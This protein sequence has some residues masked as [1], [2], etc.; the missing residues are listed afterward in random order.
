MSN[1]NRQRHTVAHAVTPS[2]Q[3]GA[4]AC[5]W[6]LS[7]FSVLTLETVW[8]REIAL[9]VGSTAVAS[10]LVIAVFFASAAL[11]NL[12]GAA[13]VEGR[14]RAL[15]FY[16]YFETSAAVSAA[17]LFVV[18]RWL[19]AHGA[20]FPEGWYGAVGA[21]ALLV[22]LPSFLSG[23]AFPSLAE[24]FVADATHR[25]STG[26]LFYG[27]NLFGAGLGVAAGGV[28]LPWHVGSQGAFFVAAGMQFA[29]GLL[30]W[31]IAVSYVPRER[32]AWPLHSVMVLPGWTGWFLLAVSGFLSLAAQTLL[33]VWARQVVEGSV[34]V[35]CGVLAVFLSGLGI[36]GLVVSA[37]RRKGFRAEDLLT[38]F[39]GTSGMLLSAV[40]TVGTVLCARDVLLKANTPSGL[41]AE[42][43]CGSAVLLLPLTFCLGGVFPVAWELVHASRK[44][45]GAVL[46]AAMALNKVGAAAGT[47]LGLFAVMPLLGLARGT[48]LIAWGYLAIACLPA[49]LLRRFAGWRAVYLVLIA[50]LGL[51]QMVRTPTVLGVHADECVVASSEGAYGPVVVVENR[52]SASR[53]ILLNSRQRLSGTQRALSSQHHQS[54]VSLLFCR[55]PSRVLTIGMAAGISATAALDFPLRELHSVE[56][57]PE[58]VDLA[59]AHFGEWN[60]AL[61]SDPRSQVHT[62]DGRAKLDRLSDGFDAIICDLFFPGE[63]GTANLYSYEF[64]RKCRQ[65]LNPGGV[66]CL[67]LPCYQHT[68]ETAGVI[69][70]TFTEVF[71]NAVALRANL[72]PLQPVLGLLGADEPIPVSK[73]FLAKQLI[74][75]VGRKLASQSVFFRSAEAAMLLFVA[76]LHSAEPGFAEFPMTTDDR[77]IFIYLGPRQPRGKERLFGFPFLDWIGKR[78]LRPVYPSCDLGKTAPEQVLAAVRAGNF[79]YAAAA[80]AAVIP[81]DPRP[82]EVRARQV[83]EYLGRA[84]ALLPE[85]E[86]SLEDVEEGAGAL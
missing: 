28:L 2:F 81:N 74:S 18:N 44:S 75:P 22:G 29:G 23:A 62:A 51:W 34:Y 12:L 32:P 4:L 25:T 6:A 46:G 57:V 48:V 68:P 19:W 53:Q 27:L 11:G 79:C 15:R 85:A 45:E 7:G 67:W 56:L 59:R 64:L 39:A 33:I 86:F 24:T 66:F 73:E 43:V 16:G 10:T 58:V 84:F 49:L 78:A 41:L 72:D 80:A 71:P 38:L 21:A 5:L 3:V 77:P 36:G 17:G 50:G 76:D 13:C 30:A 26:G 9:R 65:K 70:R 14:S 8:M 1:P 37:L 63:E 82:A 55:N 20:V 60:A 47:A 69:I 35:V 40:P 54:W 83:R 52:A 61:F 31:R 42:A